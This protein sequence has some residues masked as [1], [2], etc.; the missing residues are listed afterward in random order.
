MFRTFNLLFIFILATTSYVAQIPNFIPLNG[1]SAYLSF[2]E[3]FT[4]YNDISPYNHTTA[5]NGTLS[6]TSDRFGSAGQAVQGG[7]GSLGISENSFTYDYLDTFSISVWFTKSMNLGGRLFSTE[8]TTSNFFISQQSNIELGFHFGS[9][10]NVL[11][12][13][14][15]DVNWH[16]AVYVYEGST[17]MLYLDGIMVDVTIIDTTQ[18]LSYSAQHQIG[19]N[20]SS[21]VGLDYWDGKFDDLAIWNRALTFCEIQSIFQSQFQYSLISAG[22]DLQICVGYEIS[23]QAQ[24]A[25][26]ATWSDGV[27][28]GVPFIP[29]LSSYVLT[30]TDVNGCIGTDTLF[31]N[32]IQTVYVNQN[33]TSCTPYLFNGQLLTN[34]GTYTSSFNSILGCDSIVTVQFQ[35]LQPPNLSTTNISGNFLQTTQAPNYAYQWYNCD[36]QEPILGANDYLFQVLDSAWYQ[37]VAI[38]SCGS[39]TSECVSLYPD[40]GVSAEIS[41][42]PVILPNPNNGDF[43]ITIPTNL[44]GESIQILSIDGSTLFMIAAESTKQRCDFKQLSSGCYWVQVGGNKPIPFIKY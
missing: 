29:T 13:N 3:N 38:N 19:S 9:Q 4:N 18:V 30:G 40:A 25:V 1:L 42:V 11:L 2:Q 24:N 27:F 22:P 43:S 31:I 26:S 37:V 32:L 35:L 5:V 20:A 41:F 34:S 21:I 17:A 23:L 6:F 7:S 33:V 16:H 10:S 12:G 44:V 8:T 14:V 15:Y 39:D 28:N 36:T